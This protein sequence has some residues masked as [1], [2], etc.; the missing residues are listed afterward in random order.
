[1]TALEERTLMS[2]FLVT[3]ASELGP[4]AS[5]DVNT[6]RWAVEQSNEAATVSS[7]E[8]ELGT[9]PATI[10]CRKVPSR[11]I[12]PRTRPQFTTVSAQGP[13]TIS[14]N[15]ANQVVQ[16]EANVTASLSGLTIAGGSTTG[17]GG[18]LA[19][20]GT[21]TLTGCTVSGNSSGNLGGGLSNG[22][23]GTATLTDTIVTGNSAY[24][25]GGLY[26]NGG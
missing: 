17:N 8:I 19:N 26:N 4:A 6:L 13:V 20:Y 15:N 18:G 16:V 14:G 5:P 25:G 7:I 11:W 21:I 1:M 10:T 9:S 2:A 22:G 24:K 23:S 3:D 12:T